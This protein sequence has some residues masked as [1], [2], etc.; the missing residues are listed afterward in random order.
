M[1]T[2][3][4]YIGVGALLLL[5][6]ASLL[7]FRSAQAADSTRC[8]AETSYC[9]GGAIRIYWE[10][11]GGL[12]VFGYPIS[13]QRI[14]SVEQ[15]WTGPVQWFERDRLEDHSAEGQ[16][17]LA[18]R[19]GDRALQLQGINWQQLPGDEGAAQGCRFF[20][21]TQF[22]LCEPFL[23]YWRANGGVARFGYP[24]TRA[25]QET[26]DGRTYT[27]QYFERRRMELH[28]EN[29][30]TPYYVLL[31]LL[32]RDV[33]AAEGDRNV[34]PLAAG[35][36]ES[37]TQQLILNSAWAKL[38]P[39]YSKTPLMIGLIDIAGDDAWAL[40]L[41]QG[42]PE[43]HIYLKLES[44][45]WKVIAAETNPTA[46]PLRK[47]GMPEALLASNDRFLVIMGAL[48][49]AQDIRGSGMNGYITRPRLAGDY[50]RFW[51]APAAAENLDTV[52]MFFKRDQGTWKYLSAG[53]A[54]PE[55]DLRGLGVP[56]EI[57]PYGAS[58]RGPQ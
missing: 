15:S 22:N 14:E 6:V 17:V 45:A 51:L 53:S 57:W 56:Q 9:I 24:L 28:P 31:G 37:F 3:R 50:A 33:Y 49:Q 40:A 39:S 5:A 54:F 2:F 44:T 36:V 1:S 21:E 34:E 27:V 30:G 7:P 25:R 26:L 20:R 16:G 42:K 35:D 38:K 12:A 43:V 41:P 58:V 29:A 4:K 32:G 11:N 8:F 13:A 23:S 47:Q 10:R 55:D 18:G 48:Q 52:T 46:D 19:L